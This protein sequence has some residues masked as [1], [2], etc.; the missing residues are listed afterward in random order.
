VGGPVRVSG[1]AFGRPAHLERTDSDPVDHRL[2]R[3]R[4]ICD[5]SSLKCPSDQ[6][7]SE[8]SVSSARRSPKPRWRPR[9][10]RR[11][12]DAS[13]RA[14]AC[15]D[16][17]VSRFEVSSSRSGLGEIDGEDRGTSSEADP[18]LAQSRTVCGA[19]YRSCRS[20]SAMA[21][22]ASSAAIVRACRSTL[23]ATLG[24][25]RCECAAEV[26]RCRKSI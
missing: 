10:S 19:R 11:E 26:V 7:E 12:E 24:A 16:L 25:A 14:L 4:G 13:T 20:A 17:V 5:P 9:P 6:H 23:A 2:R 21:M 22:A 15:S 1:A 18:K 3:G 8:E